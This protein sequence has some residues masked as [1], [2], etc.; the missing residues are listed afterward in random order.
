[1]AQNTL[2]GCFLATSTSCK[3]KTGSEPVL[4]LCLVFAKLSINIS[5][6]RA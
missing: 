4:L 2:K 1:M 5:G 3:W 6:F